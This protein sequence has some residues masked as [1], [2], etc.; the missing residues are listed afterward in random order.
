MPLTNPTCPKCKGSFTKIK[1]TKIA[2]NSYLIRERECFECKNIW[3]TAQ[4]PET[5]VQTDSV[6]SR[7]S[8]SD[9]PAFLNAYN[10]HKETD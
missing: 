7:F 9:L 3:Y 10:L 1:S 6:V 2:D 8:E 4:L 5:V